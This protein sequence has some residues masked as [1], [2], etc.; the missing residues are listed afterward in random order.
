MD[1]YLVLLKVRYDI[2]IFGLLSVEVEKNIS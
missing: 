1:K 2:L